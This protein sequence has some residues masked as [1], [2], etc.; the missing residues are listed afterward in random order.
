M[1][2]ITKN[3]IELLNKSEDSLIIISLWDHWL[4]KEEFD[5]L[6]PHKGSQE[7]DEAKNKIFN[8]FIDF[9]ILFENLT[10]SFD[11]QNESINFISIDDI[12]ELKTYNPDSESLIYLDQNLKW[13]IE[14]SY[15]FCINLYDFE[16]NFSKMF[17]DK[18][19]Q[20]GLYLLSEKQYT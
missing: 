17:Q 12:H 20:N 9:I 6:F 7:Y 15:D 8:C 16:N 1:N 3:I 13:G 18:I 2:K 19:E 14:L 11:S 4:S 10:Y 5:N